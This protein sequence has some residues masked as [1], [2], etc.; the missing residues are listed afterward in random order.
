MNDVI[1]NQ[2]EL[3][4]Q[5]FTISL[6]YHS[7]PIKSSPIRIDCGLVCLCLAGTAQ[8]EANLRPYTIKKDD[9]LI[10]FPGQIM[11]EN[12]VSKDFCLAYFQFSNDWIAEIIY[13][14][15]STFIGFLKETVYYSLPSGESLEIQ[16]EYFNILYNKFNDTENVCQ[17]EIILNL[18]R[19]FY[20]DLY[21]KVIK[22]NVLNTHQR[23]RKTEMSDSFF[24]LL[25]AYYTKTREV[26][27]YAE[28][29]CITPK[30]L[31]IITQETIGSCA[32]ELI[33]RY[34]ITELKLLLKSTTISL[35]EITEK[36]DFPSEA[37]LCKYFKRHTGT[38][39]IKYRN[40]S[41]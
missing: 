15:P 2:K 27:F 8:I 24:R 20:L 26:A 38:T 17:R 33:D 19:N 7:L 25:L 41:R 21:N 9:I 11:A 14:F 35:K 29:L 37:F 40:S 12:S 36:F 39:P 16:T 31:S 34:T 1:F 6:S 28:K 10:V 30:Y 3:V 4:H 32:K 18:L 13:R 23:K 5:H 22:G